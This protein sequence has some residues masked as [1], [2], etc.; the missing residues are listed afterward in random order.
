M[1]SLKTNIYFIFSLA[2]LFSCSS[3]KKLT[4]SISGYYKIK[5]YKSTLKNKAVIFGHIYEYKTTYSIPFSVVKVNNVFINKADVNGIYSFV[6]QP[7]TCFLRS[8]AISYKF[9][10][11]EKLKISSG[12]SIRI[13]F[14]L[15]Q[16]GTPLID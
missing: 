5:I 6:I 4:P 12:D 8:T 1:R 7:Q 14:Y 11:V 15:K 2:L 9:T 10:E 16:D 3:N 13:D